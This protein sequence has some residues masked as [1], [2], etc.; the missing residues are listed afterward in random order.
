MCGVGATPALYVLVA[1]QKGSRCMY[2]AMSMLCW[3]MLSSHG[4]QVT[5]PKQTQS[6]NLVAAAGKMRVPHL[7]LR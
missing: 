2:A 5:C 4:I 6:Q 7:R 1:R 3:S